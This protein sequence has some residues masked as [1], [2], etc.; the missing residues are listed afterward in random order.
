VLK[1]KRRVGFFS[2]LCNSIQQNRLC[3]TVGGDMKGEQTL[4]ETFKFSNM[5]RSLSFIG[6]ILVALLVCACNKNDKLIDQY[7]QAIKEGNYN[8]AT[9]I[10]NKIDDEKLTDEQS[11]RILD[12]T[13]GGAASTYSAM[14]LKAMHSMGGSMNKVLNSEAVD[15]L[16]DAQEEMVDNMLDTQEEMVDH[17]LDTQE[18][19]VDDFESALD[20]YE[21][22]LDALLAE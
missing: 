19:S 5:K 14:M 6:I 7:E 13:T 11:M 3:A 21:D 17:M 18:E 12:I 16:L 22:A 9:T 4:T 8:E 1:E 10:L 15:E 20:E 2:Y